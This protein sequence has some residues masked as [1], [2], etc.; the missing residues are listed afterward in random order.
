[1]LLEPVTENVLLKD[2]LKNF[3]K[4]TRNHLCWSLWPEG[5]QFYKKVPRAQMRSGEIT[6]F[7]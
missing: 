2:G 6:K 1:M 4:F 3:T 7:L 5:P